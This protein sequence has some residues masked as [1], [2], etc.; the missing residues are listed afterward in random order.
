LK[1]VGL[2]KDTEEKSSLEKNLF[3]NKVLDFINI[4]NILHHKTINARISQFLKI[5]MSHLFHIILIKH[6]LQAKLSTNVSTNN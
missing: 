3:A 2:D 4:P 6:P 1:P 5:N